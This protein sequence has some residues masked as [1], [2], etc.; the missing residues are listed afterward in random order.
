MGGDTAMALW[1]HFAIMFEA[2]FILTT[3]DAGTRV[4]R[5]ILQD[6]LGNISPK[7]A[8]TDSWVGNVLATGL[9]VAAWGF[10]LYQGAIDPAGIAKSLWPIFGISNQLLAVIAFCLGTVVL[11]KMGKARYCWVTAVPMLFLTVVTFS[12]GYLKLFSAG[13]AGFLPEIEKQQALIATG[14]TGPA[15]K[16]AQTS[17]FNARVDV[18]VTVTFLTFVTIIVLGTARECWLLLSKRKPIV[19]RESPYVPHPGNEGVLPTSIL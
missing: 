18:V 5:F 13:A 15:L 11:I 19:L 6:L 12:A 1:Y 10:F 4:G 8:K 2:L 14:L 9:L 16:A 7:L 3:L 17:L